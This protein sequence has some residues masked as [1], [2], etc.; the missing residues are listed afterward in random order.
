MS[1]S[2]TWSKLQ[3]HKRKHEN[4][5]ERLAKRR[6]ERQDLLADLSAP[7]TLKT[8]T[9][10]SNDSKVK[11]ETFDTKYDFSEEEKVD[12]KNVKAEATEALVKLLSSVLCHKELSIPASIQEIEKFVS[13]EQPSSDIDTSYRGILVGLEKLDAQSL[14]TLQ[15][16]SSGAVVIDVELLKLQA[17]HG[18]N[19][20]NIESTVES[21]VVK[22][23]K[24]P[25]SKD[26]KINNDDHTDVVQSLLSIPTMKEVENKKLGNEILDLLNEPTAKEKSLVEKFKSQGSAMVREFCPS[27]TRE[28][29]RRANVGMGWCKKLHFRKII[30]PHTDEYLGDCS[31]LNTCFHMDTCKYVHYEVDSH[32]T[33]EEKCTEDQ[34]LSR[35]CDLAGGKITMI[36]PQ[37]IQCDVRYLDFEVLGKFSVV[38]ADPPWDIHME[39]PYGTM[40]DQEMRF[41]PVSKLQDDGYIFLWVTGRAIELGRECLLNWGYQRCDELIWVKTNQLQRLIRTG[42]TGHWINHGK[43]HCIIGVKGRPSP[44]LFNK[45]LDCDV[46]VSEVRDTSH[47]P[48][49][50]YGLIERLAPGQRKIEL[51]GRMHNVQP[52]WITLGNQLSGVNLMEP[53]VVKKFQVRYPSGLCTEKPQQKP[54]PTVIDV[55]PQQG[56]ADLGIS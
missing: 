45:G 28:E 3:E 11:T 37:W 43:E 7:E 20:M 35:K 38:M 5:K 19:Q 1:D 31:F 8:E 41:L 51:F 36:P 47:K 18:T 16:D 44:T 15:N 23:E 34:N 39:L 48:D 25:V 40:S 4:L 9:G 17:L 6:R 56:G 27:G 46:L 24:D 42:R 2:D 21:N 32:G 10:Y 13:R 30:Q 33:E 26:K 14:I 29:C 54:I 22:R 52:N 53:Q 55:T 12:I 49:E 50:I